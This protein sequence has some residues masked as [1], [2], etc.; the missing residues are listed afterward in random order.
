MADPYITAADLK[1]NAL[2]S[3]AS[4][5]AAWDLLAESVSRLFDRECEVS[6]G[7]FLPAELTATE[8]EFRGNNTEL[9]AV[10]PYLAGT[11]E[12]VDVD[13]TAVEIDSE[14]YYE[15]DGYLI[16]DFDITAVQLVSVTAR[17]GFA[18]VPAE[19]K[20]ACIEQALFMWR[21]KDL[22]FSELS[23]VPAT[24]VTAEFSPTFAAVAARYRG[25]YSQNSY[26]S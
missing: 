22:A 3:E 15:R 10:G 1:A 26:F 25:I 8:R 21:K 17:W 18:A 11:I 19:V 23:G 9:V 13:G 7:F 6:D 14:D 12:S 20:Q 4:G 2:A 5:D 24:V 16:F